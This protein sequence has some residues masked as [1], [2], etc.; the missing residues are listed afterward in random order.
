[1]NKLIN[2][3]WKLYTIRWT[4][5][6]SRKKFS[7]ETEHFEAYQVQREILYYIEV[8]CDKCLIINCKRGDLRPLGSLKWGLTNLLHLVTTL[9]HVRCE[10]RINELRY[11]A[12]WRRLVYAVWHVICHIP[13]EL[14]AQELSFFLRSFPL[15]S[16][17]TPYVIPGVYNLRVTLWGVN[18]GGIRN[19]CWGHAVARLVKALRYYS[20]GR[21]FNSG[22]CHWQDPSGRTMVLGLTQSLTEMSTRDISWGQVRP[23][24]RADKLTTFMWRLS[25]NLGASNSWNPQEDVSRPVMGLLYLYKRLLLWRFPG[26]VRSSFSCR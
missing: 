20:E 15:S 8:S 16:A 4:S 5:P 25:W 19:V 6:V 17:E 1:M 26:S 13:E 22:W 18:Y 24:R 11:S 7:Y 2:K 12:V 14:T 23:V 9:L 10:K 21:R 3:E